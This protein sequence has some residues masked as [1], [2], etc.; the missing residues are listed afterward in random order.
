MAATMGVFFAVVRLRYGAYPRPPFS[1][2]APREIRALY[3]RY[4]TGVLTVVAVAALVWWWVGPFVAAGATFVLATTGL[5]LYERTYA[6]V[7]AEVRL[8]LGIVAA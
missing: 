7:A 8:R 1:P 3:W 4:L 6:R 5:A 2:T